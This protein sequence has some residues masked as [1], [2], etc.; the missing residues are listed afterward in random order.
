V[1]N[2]DEIGNLKNMIS[3]MMMLIKQGRNDVEIA[4]CEHKAAARQVQ[5]LS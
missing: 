1:G 5:L 4:C 3:E 2:K